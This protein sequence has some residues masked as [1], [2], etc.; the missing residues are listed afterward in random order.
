MNPTWPPNPPPTRD[1]D[2]FGPLDD[3][4]VPQA[5]VL[6]EY[7]EDGRVPGEAHF[8]VLCETEEEPSVMEFST[9]QTLEEAITP[10]AAVLRSRKP[11]VQ[12]EATRSP[13]R[14]PLFVPLL[15]QAGPPLPLLFVAVVVLLALAL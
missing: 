14:A 2:R 9:G 13:E 3:V 7:P 4:D 5:E 12:R 10:S 15:A 8:P 1:D 11:T 6:G